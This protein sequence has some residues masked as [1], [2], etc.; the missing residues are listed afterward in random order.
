MAIHPTAVVDP[1]ARID[2]SVEIGPYA[3]IEGPV[4]IGPDTQIRAHAH[5]MGHTQIGRGCD[6]HPLAIVG[7]LPQDFH[8]EGKKSY[9]TI[10]DHVMIR[11]GVT[12]HR[13]TQPES[14]TVIGDECLLM[15]YAHVGHNCA[16]AR[17]VKL[18]NMATLAGHV[19]IGEMAILSAH[20]LAHQFV[21]IGAYTMASAQTRIKMDLPPFMVGHGDASVVQYNRI[22]MLRAG[23][24]APNIDEIRQAFRILYRK[25]ILF[26]KAIDEVCAMA[27]TDAGRILTAFLQAESQRGYC[28]GAG[29]HRPRQPARDNA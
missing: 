5:V 17:G 7:N 1:E 3:I 27:A 24:S 26:R 19:T 13:G 18:Y 23:F 16:L 15:A 2:P 6:I 8:F 9:C 22:G 11:E 14:T 4:T 12:I 25:G 10:G 28:M 20:S 21:R 29:R